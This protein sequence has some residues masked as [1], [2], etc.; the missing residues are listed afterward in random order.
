[1]L[2]T[3]GRY[4]VDWQREWRSTRHEAAKPFFLVEGESKMLS[5]WMEPDVHLTS[6]SGRNETVGRD[7]GARELVSGGLE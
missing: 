2:E 5:S 6:K 1:M 4:I 7:S 3:D